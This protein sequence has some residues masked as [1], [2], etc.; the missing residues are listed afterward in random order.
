MN[1]E[2][3]QTR[4]TEREIEDE[5]EASG[6]LIV[7]WVILF[8]DVLL[9]IFVPSDWRAGRWSVLFLAIAFGIVGIALVGAGLHKRQKVQEEVIHESRH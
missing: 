4:R 2:D 3:E 7:G 6:T 5:Y 1:R 9:F 8:F